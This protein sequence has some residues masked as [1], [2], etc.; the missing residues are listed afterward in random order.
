MLTKKNEHKNINAQKLNK[1]WRNL[2]NSYE[3]EYLEY[4]QGEINKIGNLVEDRKW[5]RQ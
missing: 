5:G 3:K 1:P 4:I 2:S